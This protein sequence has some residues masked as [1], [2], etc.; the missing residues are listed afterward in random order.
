[1]IRKASALFCWQVM[2]LK[3]YRHLIM[4]KGKLFYLIVF[5]IVKRKKMLREKMFTGITYGRKKVMVAFR[6]LEIFL[7]DMER[8][9][10]HLTLL[11][12]RRILRMLLFISLLILTI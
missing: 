1:M 9:S 3:C 6:R 8:N 4:G 12:L 5:S 7:K 2:K 10:L 11:P